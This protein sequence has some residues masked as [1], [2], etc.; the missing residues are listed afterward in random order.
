[1]QFLADE[2]CDFA[3]VRALRGAGD[4][5]LAVAELTPRAD[6]SAVIRLALGQTRVL[7]T[8]DKDFGQLVFA[9]GEQS[10]GVVLL[11]Y[12]IPARRVV[13]QSFLEVVREKGEQLHRCFTV[14]EP[15]KVRFKSPPE[16]G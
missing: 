10:A 3:F 14:V 4:D 9:S 16:P 15:G 11:R 2:S 1:M 12:P 13:V 7:L 8:E 5:V 6:D